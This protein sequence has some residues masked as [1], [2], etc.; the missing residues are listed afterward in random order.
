MNDYLPVFVGGGMGSA[1]R[2]VTT[3][4]VDRLFEGGKFAFGT[5]VV[6]C[7]GALRKHRLNPDAG[8][9]SDQSPNY[10][11]CCLPV[12]NGTFRC[13]CICVE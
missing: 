9:S 12:S 5:L 2:Y 3:G 8:I 1:L 7:I 11:R 10:G 6:N 4:F 13:V